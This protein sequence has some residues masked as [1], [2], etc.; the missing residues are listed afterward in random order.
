VKSSTWFVALVFALAAGVT[1]GAG[2]ALQSSGSELADRLGLQ[3]SG[4]AAPGR[5]M[6]GIVGA[7]VIARPKRTFLRVGTGSIAL[8]VIDAAV[9][10][11]LPKVT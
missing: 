5:L 6:T 10:A 11:L 9:I 3:T 4:S 7:A 2:V 1:L 8:V